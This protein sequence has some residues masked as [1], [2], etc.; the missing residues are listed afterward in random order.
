MFEKLLS[1]PSR[2]IN[3]LRTVMSQRQFLIFSA[4]LVG[5][6][7]GLAIVVLKTFV[8]WV[9]MFAQ[10]MDDRLPLRFLSFLLPLV[11]LLLTVFIIQRVFNG[12]L[13]K[14]SW[15]IIAAIFKNKSNLNKKHM[16]AHIIT[17]SITVGFGGSAGIESPVT[18]T[19]AA[20][21]SNFARV[22]KFSQKERSLL[23]A[24]GVSSAVAAA[25]NAPVTGILFTFEVLF[26]DLGLSGFIPLMLSTASGA[27]L[28]SV[29]LG[30]KILFKFS[31]I[32]AFSF[33]N[34]PFYLVLGVFTGVV[35][36]YHKRMFYAIEG[37]FEKNKLSVYTKTVL[38][39]LAL[40]FLI[41]L[42]PGLFGEGYQT[43]RNLLNSNES[44]ILSTTLFGSESKVIVLLYVFLLILVKPIAT[45]ITLGAGGN[46]GSF[47]PALFLGSL[48]GYFTSYGINLLGWFHTLP[49]GN[50][51][52]I[53]MA[54]L[55]SGLF[56][57]PL[58]S[59][60]LIAE[61]TG[62]YQL[63]IPLMIVSAL[64][65]AV[66]RKFAPLS[67]DGIKL[68]QL[69]LNVSED[70]DKQILTSINRFACLHSIDLVAYETSDLRT[71]LESIQHSDQAIIPVLNDT[72]KVIGCI[73]TEDL[74]FLISWDD[75]SLKMSV[76]QFISLEKITGKLEET[77][78]EY[79]D[80]MNT[81][82]RNALL[83]L[84]DDAPY[85]WISKSDLLEEYRKQVQD[86]NLD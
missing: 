32:E 2:Y 33:Q 58:T 35:A 11:G 30:E 61:I 48:C 24:C 82:D 25:F 51:T 79:L 50:F 34:L 36:V 28:A 77:T 20:F 71:I 13:E 5:L 47:A 8:Y 54:G 22:F 64:S 74:P 83:I 84:K 14:G 69:N 67:L 4:V 15:R 37:F 70:K 73:Y 9:F 31:N 75:I 81:A 46:G 23:L 42:L 21:G 68:N 44:K 80:I 62:G 12:N 26:M 38:G 6:S 10:Y 56:H 18:I 43:I 39:A 60:F 16:Y 78:E 66:S 19:G 29:L 59:I 52:M 40:C 55:I 3:Y 63:M 41:F 53:G 85:G 7:S 86:H 17:S 72:D 65:F 76:K 57:A 49:V 1:F 27:V 45:G